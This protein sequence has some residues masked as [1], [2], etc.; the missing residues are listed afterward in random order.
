MN[1]R[2]WLDRLLIAH[3]AYGS[4]VEVDTFVKWIFKQYGMIYP[5]NKE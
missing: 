3:R 4:S 5:E 2:E 1:E